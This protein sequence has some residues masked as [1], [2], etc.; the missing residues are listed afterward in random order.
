MDNDA[1]SCLFFFGPAGLL[2]IIAAVRYFVLAKRSKKLF[3]FFKSTAGENKKV[4]CKKCN[5]SFFLENFK[6][7]EISFLI[8]VSKDDIINKDCKCHKAL[9]YL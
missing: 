8:W 9:D 2:I 1:I 5:Q 6:S 4:V 3:Y 7:E